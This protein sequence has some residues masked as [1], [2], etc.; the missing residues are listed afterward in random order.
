MTEVE[1]LINEVQVTEGVCDITQDLL[2]LPAGHF[3][4][5]LADP[6]WRFENSTGKVAPEHRRL[7]RYKSM[8][9]DEIR[10]LP[11][12]RIAVGDAWWHRQQH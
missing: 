10:A 9:L 12:E 1:D 4:T 8:T 2:Q 3:R 5:A 7:F 6:P 11:V